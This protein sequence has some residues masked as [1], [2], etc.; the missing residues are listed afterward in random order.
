MIKGTDEINTLLDDHIVATQGMSFSPYKA[1][2]LERIESWE[3]LLRLVQDIT[4]E[5]L[6]VQRNWMYLQPIF[7]SEDI[8][9]Q[10]PTESKKF[11][12]A[13]RVYRK[14]L[15]TCFKKPH[16]LV[17]RLPRRFRTRIAT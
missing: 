10:L 17:R 6:A 14:I 12:E 7:E 3:A 8:A 5:W 9:R 13:D 15:F 11:K 4:T 16:V 2:F 1:V